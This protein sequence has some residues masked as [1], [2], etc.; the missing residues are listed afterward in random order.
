MMDSLIFPALFAVLLEMCPVSLLL[1]LYVLDTLL[2]GG[3]TEYMY[4]YDGY[5]DVV[6]ADDNM[7]MVDD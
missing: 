3:Q 1:C 6:D 2:G 5:G 7:N 4:R